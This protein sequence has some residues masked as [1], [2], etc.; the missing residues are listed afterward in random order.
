[1]SGHFSEPNAGSD[2]AN[3][4]TEARRDGDSYIVNGQKVWNSFGWAAD[5]CAL[6]TRS[7]PGSPKTQGAH[8]PARAT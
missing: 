2:L 5:W 7:E 3:V 8:L 6:V 4:R 1:V